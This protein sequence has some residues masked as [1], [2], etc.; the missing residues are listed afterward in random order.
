[1]YAGS[2]WVLVWLDIHVQTGIQ[3]YFFREDSNQLSCTIIYKID[4]LYKKYETQ[5]Y[6]FLHKLID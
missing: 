6:V 4:G 1:M 5:C 3:K 2:Q